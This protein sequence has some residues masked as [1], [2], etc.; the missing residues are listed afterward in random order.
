[1]FKTEY[2]LLE[3][4][5]DIMSENHHNNNNEI[6]HD[7]KSSK[8]N[9]WKSFAMEHPISVSISCSI[10]DSLIVSFAISALAFPSRLTNIENSIADINDNIATLVSDVS[11]IKNGKIGEINLN[12]EFAIINGKLETLNSQY[13]DLAKRTEK[14][15]S[16]IFDVVKIQAYSNVISTIATQFSSIKDENFAVDLLFTSN[17][18]VIAVDTLTLAEYT[19]EQLVDEKLLLTYKEDDNDVVFYGQFNENNHWD[20]NCIINV[21][22]NNRPIAITE[23]FYE[24]GNLH[25][26]KQAFV[27]TDISGNS[28]W[29]I[30]SRVHTKEYNTGKTMQYAYIEQK[31]EFEFSD[32]TTE[33]IIDVEIFNKSLT[34]ELESFY[35]GN[36]SNGQFNDDTGS[37]YYISYDYLSNENKKYIKTLYVGNFKDGNFHD[38]TGKAWYITKAADTDYMYYIGKFEDGHPTEPETKDNFI[39]PISLQQRNEIIK[40]KKFDCEIK[41]FD[42]TTSL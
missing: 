20:G 18:D 10:V 23:G 41:W 42:D 14:L 6:K 25:T 26:Y 9:F 34:S 38:T 17:T 32:V 4:K 22:N 11:D 21:Y 7:K 31:K 30:S 19:V 24:D 13:D 33:D 35:H 15:E 39:N 5:V 29:F 36:T 40:D 16:N 8:T 28:K 12:T 1:M 37:A 2:M 27:D 3:N